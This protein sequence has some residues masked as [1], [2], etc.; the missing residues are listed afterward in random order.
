VYVTGVAEDQAEEEL[1][2]RRLDKVD[3]NSRRGDND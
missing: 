1:V 3:E 2:E